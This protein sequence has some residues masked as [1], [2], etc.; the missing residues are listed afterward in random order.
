LYIIY[1]ILGSNP[2]I[3]ENFEEFGTRFPDM[4]EVYNKDLIKLASDV[5]KELKMSVKVGIYYASLG[6]SFETPAEISM[7]G[8]MGADLV[9]M[10]TIPEAIT[11]NYC[12]I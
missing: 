1:V 7:A 9:G 10:S 3:G 11:A 6:P 8:K 4:S 2:L 5:M 12:G